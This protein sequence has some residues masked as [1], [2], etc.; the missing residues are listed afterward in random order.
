MT[1][2]RAPAASHC[3]SG[4]E[5][6]A[7]ANAPAEPRT[8]AAGMAT[9]KNPKRSMTAVV[10]AATSA[11]TLPLNSAPATLASIACDLRLPRG[12]ALPLQ[13]GQKAR[14]HFAGRG[15]KRAAMTEFNRLTIGAVLNR[16]A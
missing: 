1:P 9:F 2:T 11:I 12:Y 15:R 10:A 16:Q 8:N 13:R 4:A 6:A 7:K 14:R 5:A 3:N